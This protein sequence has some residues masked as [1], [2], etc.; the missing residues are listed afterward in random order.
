MSDRPLVLLLAD[1]ESTVGRMVSDRFDVVRG[2]DARVRAVVGTG[3]SR[4]PADLISALPALGLIALNGVGYDGVDVA[5][6]R[7]RGVAV[8][9]TPDVLTDDVADQAIALMLAVLR[10]TAANDR[11]VREGRWSVPLARRVSGRTVG[12]F[13]LGRIG[14]AIAM[15]AA[16][17]AGEIVY[18]SRRVY[19]D[20]PW[21]HLPN[22]TA[23]A[24][25]SDVLILAAAATRDTAHVVDAGVLRALGAEGVLV[26]IARGSLVD[27][28]ALVE[29]LRDGTIAG[30]G[31]DVFADEPRVPE[32]LT[33]MEH[34]VLAPHQA[35]ATVETRAAMAELVVAN[36]EALFAGRA[37]VTPLG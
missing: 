37:L 35:S 22:I 19:A 4:V 29:A 33:G 26:N 3:M 8:T 6:A 9:T 17:F 36:L 25:A 34:V 30:A 14:R 24:E 27:E 32:A 31:L 10:R 16:P 11:A 13:G 1:P 20:V 21:R 28:A 5:A 15:R 18:A 12:I 23:L 7:A 2:P